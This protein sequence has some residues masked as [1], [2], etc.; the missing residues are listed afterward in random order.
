M[1]SNLA[2]KNEE[3]FWDLPQWTYLVKETAK[4]FRL[5]DKEICKLENSNTAKIIATIPFEAKC[6]D[7]ERTAIAHLCLYVAEIQGYQKFC[8]HQISDDA[9]LFNRLSFISTFVK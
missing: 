3:K 5:T 7:P 4:V 9:N 2:L 8:S 1:N 6:K